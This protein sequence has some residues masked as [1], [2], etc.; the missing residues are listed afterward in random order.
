MYP[1]SH[2]GAFSSGWK[3]GKFICI[4]GGKSSNMHVLLEPAKELYEFSDC[5]VS[6]QFPPHQPSKM[7]KPCITGNNHGF[8]IQCT[9]CK[10]LPLFL[11]DA[12]NIKISPWFPEYQS[13]PLAHRK[14]NVQRKIAFSCKYLLCLVTIKKLMQ[15]YFC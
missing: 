10:A 3:R 2:L 1:F 13:I 7:V 15:N 14:F 9:D 8:D 6:F 4:S 12:N 11:V 5:L